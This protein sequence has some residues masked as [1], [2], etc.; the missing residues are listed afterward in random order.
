MPFLPPN[1]PGLPLRFTEVEMHASRSILPITSGRFR[2]WTLAIAFLLIGTFAN[3]I[4]AAAESGAGHVTGTVLDPAGHPLAGAHVK[5]DS[6][7]AARLTVTTGSDGGFTI[8]LP[9][10][11]AYI[12]RVVA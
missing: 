5:L 3:T 2:L 4:A 9:T 11:G 6:T 8:A 7:F 10:W 1:T 12:V